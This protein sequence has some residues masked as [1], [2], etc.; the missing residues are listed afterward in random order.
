MSCLA[1]IKTSVLL[2]GDSFARIRS[3]KHDSFTAFTLVYD[4]KALFDV[5][6]VMR[7]PVLMTLTDAA[8]DEVPRFSKTLNVVVD[9][10]H[11]LEL[12]A[13]IHGVNAAA[14]SAFNPL[15]WRMVPLFL[16]LSGLILPHDS[17]GSHLDG[18]RKTI[19]ID[20][21]KRN[22]F[23]AAEVLSDVW[24]KT[25]INSHPIDCVGYLLDKA[26]NHRQ[27]TFVG[28]HGSSLGVK[29]SSTI[30]IFSSD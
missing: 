4:T 6:Q 7:W 22:L 25:V 2:S 26:M 10:F 21:E 16:D 27:R 24:S 5:P 3:G 28:C 17:F 8:A 9:L 23:K 12:D 29:A 13:V 14:L 18:N 1:I 30:P 19:D 20:L 15:E 11:L